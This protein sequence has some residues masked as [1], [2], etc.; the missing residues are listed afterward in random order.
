MSSFRR[1]QL[2]ACALGAILLASTNLF[3]AS[4]GDPEIKTNDTYFPGELAMS[5]L[6]R[7]LAHAYSITRGTVGS[8]TQHDKLIKLFLWRDEHYT[9][10]LS[11]CIY[12]NPTLTPSPSVDNPLEIDYDTLRAMFSYSWGVCGTN[13]AQMRAIAEEAGFPH[14]RRGLA[15]DTG[16]ELYE[17]GGW[18]YVNTDQYTLHFLTNSESSDFAS[19]D[20]VVSTNH[21]YIE[22]NPDL[23][24]GYFMP[25]ANTHGGY[26]TATGHVIS[27]IPYRS[28]QWQDYYDNVWNI[29]PAN[30]DALYGE[31]YACTPIVYR[32][33]RGETFTRWETPDGSVTDLGLSGRAWWGYDGGSSP[34]SAYSFVQNAPA[35]DQTTGG[36]EETTKGGGQ[37]YGNGCFDW[38][39]SLAN[40]EYLDGVVD[41]TGTFT[42]GGSPELATA[43]GGTLVFEFTTPYTMCGVVTQT[44]GS[45]HQDPALV[46]TGG[47]MLYTTHSGSITVDISTD[48]GASWTSLGSLSNTMDFTDYV[49]G[50]NSYL[51]RLTFAAAAGL[52]TFHTRTLVMVAQSVYPDLVSG[53]TTVT[54]AAGK[55]GMLD[56]SPSLW[57]AAAASSSTGY[58]TKVSDSGLTY[59][60]YTS[61]WAYTQAGDAATNIVYKIVL[62]PNLVAQGATFKQIFAAE[63]SEVHD[64]PYSGTGAGGTIF[65]STAAGGPWTQIGQYTPT[66]DDDLSHYWTY[67]RSADPTNLGG[68]TY[69]VKFVAYNFGSGS[70]AFRYFHINATYNLPTPTTPLDVTYY[71]NNGSN[72][73]SS[74]TVAAGATSD[75]WTITTGT[76]AAQQKVVFSVPSGGVAAPV[77]TTQPANTTVMAPATATFSVVASG[78]GLSYQWYL[79]GSPIGGATSASYTTPATTTGNNGE[80]FTVKVTNAGGSVLSNIATL[81][82]T[83][84]GAPTITTQPTDQTVTA[85]ATATFTVVA[86]GATSYQ[87]NLNGTPIGGA[88]SASYTTGATVVAD[89]GKQYTV[90][91]T[92]SSGSITSNIATLFANGSSSTTNVSF[93]DGTSSYTGEIDN[94]VNQQSPTVAGSSVN[95][96][97]DCWFDTAPENDLGLIQFDLSSIPTT[98]TITSAQLVLW[99]DRTNGVDTGDQLIFSTCTSS[100]NES[101]TYNTMPT[102][103]ATSVVPPTVAIANASPLS[104]T[105]AYT[106]TGMASVVQGWVS[107]PATNYG[108]LLNYTS[109]SSINMSFASHRDPTVANHPELDVTY[110]SGGAAPTITTQPT[111]QTVAQPA[112]ATF[113]VVATGGTSYQWLKNGVNI[114]GATAASYT[115]PATTPSDNGAT[116]RVLVIGST[117]SVFSNTVTLTVTSSGSAP[118]ITTQ[119]SN[120]T[121]TAPA[122]A[123]FSVVATGATSYQWYRNGTLIGGATSASYTTPATTTADS[124]STFKVDCINSSGT[125]TSSTVTL[126]VNPAAGAP[127]ITTQP[128]NITVTAPA[129]A[130][131]TVVASGATSY[132]WYKNG[133]AIGG[134][135]SASYTTPATTTADSGSTFKVDCTN[136]SGTTTSSTVT[137]TVLASGSNPIS[138]G[139]TTVDLGAPTGSTNMVTTTITLTNSSGA[140]VTVTSSSGS[141]WLSGSTVTVPAGGTATLSVNGNPTGMTGVV[142]GTLSLTNSSGGSQTLAV[143]MT[144]GEAAG[145]RKRS[146]DIGSGLNPDIYTLLM[147]LLGLAALTTVLRRRSEVRA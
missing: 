110:S 92:N 27:S 19:V 116:F 68:T 25:Q 95:N 13:H 146:C 123:T 120:V 100:W 32:L 129:T 45:G 39:P 48:M 9:H 145:L 65:I 73:S 53:T 61:S 67:G 43:A 72:Q 21:R 22:W 80:Q 75:S 36:T 144:V 23:G 125:T 117:G 90:T 2:W 6:P 44:N 88:T 40:S 57:T 64:T 119:P 87:W 147:G 58:T 28:S 33:K 130:T 7:I 99:I 91:V 86:T 42:V 105:Q 128:S 31:G 106:I 108:A 29:L 104:P 4:V 82:V 97:I 38:Q 137:L 121:V 141:S 111:N 127:T 89:S 70:Q 50:R 24:G 46:C 37:D 69:Y 122:T 51:L 54:Y 103:A 8:S 143:S 81:T 77:I 63:D 118:V 135:T 112:T 30:C 140:P 12:N 94:W 74:H 79:G 17:T 62:P 96:R 20:Q 47:G 59:A 15:G 102:S 136:S 133:T 126:T 85:P 55:M 78:T 66:T 26:H 56:L 134:A 35:R 60:G 98:A 1:S 49:K 109:P 11:P 101:T 84:A 18:R 52:D 142:S 10:E 5:T 16:Q 76:V 132:Q 3:A 83:A 107:T 114:N 138:V 41:Q 139:V 93:Q 131:F 115:T 113:S 71:W 124:G 14:R 34:H